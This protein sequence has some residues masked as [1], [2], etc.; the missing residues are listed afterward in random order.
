MGRYQ[1]KDNLDLDMLE[2]VVSAFWADANLA[3]NKAVGAT[4]KRGGRAR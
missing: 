2:T 3:I 1:L 4:R